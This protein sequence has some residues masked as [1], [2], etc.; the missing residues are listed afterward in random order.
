MSSKTGQCWEH[1]I[2]R[3]NFMVIGNKTLQFASK[4]FRRILILR[5]PVLCLML[6]Q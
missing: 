5:S 3:K 1:T 2:Q 4:S 6:W